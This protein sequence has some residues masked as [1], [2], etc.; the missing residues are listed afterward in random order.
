[1]LM[2]N[3]VTTEITVVTAMI[4]TLILVNQVKNTSTATLVTN[5]V[6]NVRRFHVKFLLFLSDV[7]Q[8]SL[9]STY[10]CKNNTISEF[11]FKSIT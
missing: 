2:V 3:F 4:G 6:I 10:F 8:T 5:T 11:S 1:M 9:F 7:K